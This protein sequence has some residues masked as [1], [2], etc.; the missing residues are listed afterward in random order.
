MGLTELILN[1]TTFSGRGKDT[2]SSFTHRAA[3]PQA[4][5][6]ASL[7][8]NADLR[9][10]QPVFGSPPL[11]D[12]PPEQSASQRQSIMVSYPALP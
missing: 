6:M 9:A 8:P 12:C 11:S 3:F 4:R 10:M 7:L 1:I 2:L 5:E